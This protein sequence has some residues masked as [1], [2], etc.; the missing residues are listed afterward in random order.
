MYSQQTF[1][2]TTFSSCTVIILILSHKLSFQVGYVRLDYTKIS[3]KLISV[4]IVN[5][6]LN[7]Q[8]GDG[9]EGKEECLEPG[10]RHK[11]CKQQQA[12]RFSLKSMG[13]L[14]LL[15]F[16]NYSVSLSLLAGFAALEQTAKN[17]RQANLCWCCQ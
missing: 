5:K 17:I 6:T 10:E 11:L 15:L 16:C 2:V 8:S 1:P 13:E 12:G 9:T 3:D 14:L 4:D 7:C